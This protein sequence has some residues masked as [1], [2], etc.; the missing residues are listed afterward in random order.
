MT[1]LFD[2][3]F[4]IK[5]NF[6][7]AD[8]QMREHLSLQRIHRWENTSHFS[9]STDERTPLTWADLQMREHLSL[10]RIYRWEHLSLQRI[11]RWENTS[12]FSGSTHSTDERAHV[13][14]GHLSSKTDGMLGH[15]SPETYVETLCCWDTSGDIRLQLHLGDNMMRRY[16]INRGRLLGQFRES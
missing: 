12:H 11:H 4:R 6:T 9:G 15:L 7:S 3:L 14:R 2:P 13:F 8:P 16:S 1:P 10:Q 5:G